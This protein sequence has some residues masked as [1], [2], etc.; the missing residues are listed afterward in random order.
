[1]AVE[2]ADVR[3]HLVVRDDHYTWRWF[4]AFGPNVVKWFLDLAVLPQDASANPAGYTT[5]EV[6]TN[7]IALSDSTDGQQV[8]IT[9]GGTEDNGLQ[10]Q[11]LGE[12]FS[13]AS[14]YPCYFGCRFAVNDA[15]AVDVF[16]GLAIQD[17]TMLAGCSD[18]IGFRTDDGVTPLQFI[19]EKDSLESSTS[20][21]TLTDA[22]WVEAEFYFDGAYVYAYVNKV[23]QATVAYTDTNFPDNEHLTPTI[24]ILTGDNSANTLT[25]AW[26][27]A[28]QIYST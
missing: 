22:G 23:L 10:I 1:M 6:G 19:L 8:L 9:T 14:G 26:A 4:D 18:D 17:T 13:F 7:T 24:A 28:I 15:D 20:V 21:G 5:T 25:V 3:G 11:P 12:S 2:T 16:V 27:R